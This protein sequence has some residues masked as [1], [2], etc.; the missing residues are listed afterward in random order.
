MQCWAWK[1]LN[2]PSGLGVGWGWGERWGYGMRSSGSP[3]DILLTVGLNYRDDHTSW[4]IF[5][6]T[7]LFNIVLYVLLNCIAL[8]IWSS[9]HYISYEIMN[10]MTC[11][12]CGE[13]TG[14]FPSQRPVKRSFGVF[15]D[16]RLNKRLSN[17]SWGWWFETL[18]R[19]L[20]RHCN[21]QRKLVSLM[22]SKAL[23]SSR[24][25]VTYGTSNILMKTPK[26]SE[27]CH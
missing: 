18:S 12:F 10:A 3:S 16:L 6:F 26:K 21:A 2:K 25:C 23:H 11:Y 20:W 8:S 24:R 5:L 13:F 27:W 19:P 15:S 9:P 17:Q 14:E 1:L 4:I 7:N 22:H